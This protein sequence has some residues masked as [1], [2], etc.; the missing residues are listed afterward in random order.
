MFVPASKMA[1]SGKLPFQSPIRIHQTLSKEEEDTR[2]VILKAGRKDIP[3][4]VQIRRDIPV[5]GPQVV[6]LRAVD[7]QAAVLTVLAHQMVLQASVPRDLDRAVLRAADIQGAVSMV[8]TLA[9]R[10]E[11]QA[12][13]G[14]CT[15]VNTDNNQTGVLL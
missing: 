6:G 11:H 4:L 9:N 7:L 1:L 8:E 2:A 3:K 12:Q 5:A 13:G 10:R 15:Y 14:R